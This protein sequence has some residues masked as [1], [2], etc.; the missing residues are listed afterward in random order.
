MEMVIVVGN[1]SR[2]A[3][4]ADIEF[5]NGPLHWPP[6]DHNWQ[7]EEEAR[8]CVMN[9]VALDEN[10][11]YFTCPSSPAPQHFPT[12]KKTL[13]LFLNWASWDRR[14]VPRLFN[15]L[16]RSQAP[17]L[18]EIKETPFQSTLHKDVTYR[19]RH[20]E[21]AWIHLLKSG[22]IAKLK[23]LCMCNYDFLLAALQT[24]SVSYLRCLLEHV[25]CYLLDREIE[26][27]YFS[28]KMSTDVL[29]RDSFQ[30]GTQNMRAKSKKNPLCRNIFLL[31]TNRFASLKLISWLRPVTERGG[32]LMSDLVT[33]AMAWCDGFTLPLVV[34]LNDW[35]Q[36][37]LPSQAKS[38]ITPDV[39]LIECT[40]NGQHVVVV[41][42]TDPQ[43]W[44]IMTNQLVHTFKDVREE[45]SDRLGKLLGRFESFN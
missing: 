14:S 15:N 41:A 37:P 32:G 28:I 43:L 18:S 19:L 38:M 17:L 21:E 12:Q 13:I 34:P 4:K 36:P 2:I 39:R 44:H 6:I 27:V 10:I 7:A 45:G 20:V 3:R 30:L 1:K 31:Y 42:D 25:R 5:N 16:K 33:S 8:K 40:P 22:D 24:F 9:R 29:T 11:H 23:N 35:L 26:L